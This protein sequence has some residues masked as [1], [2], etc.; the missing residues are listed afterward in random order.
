M[1]PLRPV[2]VPSTSFCSLNYSKG[3]RYAVVLHSYIFKSRLRGNWLRGHT[4]VHIE[5]KT[6]S[7][8]SFL[9]KTIFGLYLGC[10]PLHSTK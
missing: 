2:Y 6:L 4:M 5:A 10:T 1:A 7:I 3:V 9:T 8:Y